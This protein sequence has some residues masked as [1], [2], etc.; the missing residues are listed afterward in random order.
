MATIKNMLHVEL[1]LSNPVSETCA[2]IAHV[3][4]AWPGKEGEILKKLSAEIDA[5]LD[6]LRGDV[7]DG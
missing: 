5:H 4:A 1:D 7:K 6:R 3:L 2:V